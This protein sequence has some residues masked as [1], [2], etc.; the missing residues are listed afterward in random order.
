MLTAVRK[1]DPAASARHINL[2]LRCL[3][4]PSPPN[5]GDISSFR[6]VDRRPNRHSRYRIVFTDGLRGSGRL[7]AAVSILSARNQPVSNRPDLPKFSL[8]KDVAQ[9]ESVVFNTS[10]IPSFGVSPET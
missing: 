5:L 4:N 8:Q 9:D 6:T 10:Q 3:Q 1:V 7:N 2:P